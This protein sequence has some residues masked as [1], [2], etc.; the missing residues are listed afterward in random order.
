MQLTPG[1]GGKRRERMVFDTFTQ[2]G[3]N[4]WTIGYCWNIAPGSS[5]HTVTIS[6]QSHLPASSC[7]RPSP[8][9]EHFTPQGML[10]PCL[11][12]EFLLSLLTKRGGQCAIEEVWKEVLPVK[13]FLQCVNGCIKFADWQ[14]KIN[15]NIR[16]EP[17]HQSILV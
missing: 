6:T 1:G 4:P 9:Q 10:R 5:L 2:K 3:N 12:M 14:I 16:S 17:V 15:K 7:F 13:S 8:S 11:S